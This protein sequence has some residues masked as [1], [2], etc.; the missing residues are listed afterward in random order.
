MTEKELREKIGIGENDLID[1]PQGLVDI[2]KVK[3]DIVVLGYLVGGVK[4][5]DINDFLK[6]FRQK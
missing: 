4:K 2:L 3:D 5:V 6:G 1:S